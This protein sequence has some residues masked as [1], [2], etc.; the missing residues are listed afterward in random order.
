MRDRQLASKVKLKWGQMYNQVQKDSIG[1]IASSADSIIPKGS[2]GTML[3]EHH[4]SHLN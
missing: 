3:I 1:D 2:R 4:P